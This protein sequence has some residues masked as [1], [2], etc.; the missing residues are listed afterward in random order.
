M[1]NNVI[2][3]SSREYCYAVHHLLDENKAQEVVFIVLH[4]DSTDEWVDSQLV[5]K[6]KR[7]ARGWGVKG[8]TVLPLWPV[9]VDNYCDLFKHH[10]PEGEQNETAF[11]M[12]CEQADL[13]VCVWGEHGA[14]EDKGQRVAEILDKAG[15]ELLA[16]GVGYKGEPSDINFLHHTQE[17]GIYKP[18]MTHEQWR[19]VNDG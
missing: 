4:A 11:R 6:C 1:I 10:K 14:W 13:V 2:C 3:D 9:R 18:G 12:I 17:V 15:V 8:V 16:F 19:E 5:R 7:V